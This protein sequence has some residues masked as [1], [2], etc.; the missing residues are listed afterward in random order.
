MRK[1]GRPK[2]DKYWNEVRKENGTLKCKRCG[3]EFSD[4]TSVT[5]IKAHLKGK[6]GQG[7]AICSPHNPVNDGVHNNNSISLSGTIILSLLFLLFL[8]FHF[9]L[10]PL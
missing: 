3:H 4:K 10:Y 1:P 9:Y 6:Q 7:A 2:K 8:Y 5:R